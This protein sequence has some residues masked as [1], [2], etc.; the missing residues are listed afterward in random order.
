[1]GGNIFTLRSSFLDVRTEPVLHG[2]ARSW[3]LFYF[4]FTAKDEN[5]KLAY[6]FD[7]P[8]FKLNEDTQNYLSRKV[9]GQEFFNRYEKEIKKIKF[10]EIIENPDNIP[11]LPRHLLILRGVTATASARL[12]KL[13]PEEQIQTDIAEFM[14][15]TPKG[16]KR[17][18]KI[19]CKNYRKTSEVSANI[20]I[21]SEN[22]EFICN[23]ESSHF[24]NSLWNLSFLD[25]NT[26]TFIFKMHNNT[27]GY[28]H[29]VAHFV[30]NHSPNCTFCDMMEVEENEPE[31]PIHLFYNCPA[32]E[33]VILNIF[34]WILDKNCVENNRIKRTEYFG[35]MTNDN[36]NKN[37]VM[38]VICK[39]FQKYIWDCKLRHT[40]PVTWHA[41]LT[42]KK[43]FELL[44]DC[45]KKFRQAFADSNIIDVFNRP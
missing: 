28:N 41:K 10:S 42:I 18:R 7:N 44:M 45:T 34:C 4:A 3:E 29:S 40:L 30:N 21:F 24:L 26:R 11:F 37:L 35:M 2:L 12:R 32:V 36:K 13:E 14:E 15:R 6:V 43:E 16:S 31:T 20:K 9:F 8:V 33:P 22:C 25:N 5:Y 39:I 17:F 27:L 38:G 23:L 1:M 19:I